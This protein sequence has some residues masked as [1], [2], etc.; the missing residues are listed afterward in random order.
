MSGVEPWKVNS[1]EERA[2]ER[3]GRG[4]PYSEVQLFFLLR[5]ERLLRIRR[6]HAVLSNTN[7]WWA[8]L[9]TKAIYSTYCDC[10]ESG[11]GEDA[12]KLFSR[13]QA[14]APN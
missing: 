4:R 10:I 14:S 11:V 12:R 13:D 6:E 9:L 5:M 3:H 1:I 2:G 8:K 7:D